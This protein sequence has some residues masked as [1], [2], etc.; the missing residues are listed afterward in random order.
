MLYSATPISIT[1][2]RGFKKSAGTMRTAKTPS[3]EPIKDIGNSFF[4]SS[5]SIFPERTNCTKLVSE[6]IVAATLLVARVVIGGKPVHKSAG[7]DIRPPPP[8]TESINEATNPITA[9]KTA[10]ERSGISNILISPVSYS[11]AHISDF[12]RKDSEM[13]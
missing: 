4:I 12:R 6:P 8:T 5:V 1:I 9:K 11:K 3:T 13:Q 2:T 7:V 10:V